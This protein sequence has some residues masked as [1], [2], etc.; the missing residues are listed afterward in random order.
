MLLCNYISRENSHID[1]RTFVNMGS[2]RQFDETDSSPMETHEETF[3][4]FLL[5]V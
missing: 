4:P 2:K 3:S 1:V 5:E